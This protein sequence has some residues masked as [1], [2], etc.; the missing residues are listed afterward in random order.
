M[1]SWWL[2]M[3]ARAGKTAKASAAMGRRAAAPRAPRLARRLKPGLKTQVGGP[4]TA[5]AALVAKAWAV[6]AKAGATVTRPARLLALAPLAAVKRA[7]V[8]ASPPP[9]RH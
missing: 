1:R 6:R 8:V 7:P 3:A 5:A 2:V 9:S 4:A